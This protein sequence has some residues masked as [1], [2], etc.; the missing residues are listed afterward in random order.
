MSEPADAAFITNRMAWLRLSS[1]LPAATSILL[2]TDMLTCPRR[3]YIL[4]EFMLAQPTLPPT[5]YSTPTDIR[6]ACDPD[7]KVFELAS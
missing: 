7:S 5:A 4:Y 2:H 3:Y 1:L 6:T